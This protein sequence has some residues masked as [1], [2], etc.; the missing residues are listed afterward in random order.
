MRAAAVVQPVKVNEAPMDTMARL[1]LGRRSFRGGR[2]W[3]LVEA[4]AVLST[5]SV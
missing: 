2:W 5:R 3:L 1:L 4:G